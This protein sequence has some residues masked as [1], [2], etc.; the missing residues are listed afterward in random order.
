MFKVSIKDIKDSKNNRILSW[1]GLF[2]H[3]TPQIIV[4]FHKGFLGF[5]PHESANFTLQSVPP[6]MGTAL[7][8]VNY[9]ART[10]VPKDWYVVGHWNGSL[11]VKSGDIVW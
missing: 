7:G 4:P 9:G 5:Q 8:P 2:D 1:F 6:T 11:S 3:G 10:P